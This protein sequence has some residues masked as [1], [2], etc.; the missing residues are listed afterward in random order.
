MRKPILARIA[1]VATA[2]PPGIL[3][4]K[5]LEK[6]V[7]TNDQW[8]VERTGIRQRHIV[9]K[10]V[11]SS[12]LGAEAASKVLKKANLDPKDVDL[13]IVATITPDMQLPAIACLVQ[14]KIGATNAW[15]FDVS[16]ACSG[17]L[18]SLQVAVQFIASGAHKNI[19]VVGVDVMS[20]IID[21]T[22]RST[23]IIFGDGGGAVL[24]QASE[25]EADGCFLDFIHESDGSGGE[26]LSLPGGGSKHP[27]THETVDQK[28]HF[29]HQDGPAVFKFAT[30]KMAELAVKV[31]ERNGLRGEDV[32]LFVP[33]QANLRIIQSAVERLK[34]P[35]EKV[36]V[37]IDEFGN[38]TAGTLP[39]AL[40]SAIEQ[41]RLKKGDLVLMASMGAGF[42]AGAAIFRWGY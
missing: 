31:L 39:I 19:I 20:S 37:N 4:N 30:R 14:N 28:L 36:I 34:A 23:C 15:A 6:M 11:T 35:M 16:A 5:D 24:V 27:A 2:V 25:S 17:F 41:G 18:Y 42:T 8:I 29:V 33:H 7:E 9:E 26:S 13:I 21:Y 32:D 1:A 40:N 10:G 12:D 38:T 22:D 3:S